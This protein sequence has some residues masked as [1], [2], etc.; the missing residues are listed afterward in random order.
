MGF[1]ARLFGVA[2]TKSSAGAPARAV[3]LRIGGPDHPWV[4]EPPDDLAQVRGR[5]LEVMAEGRP[6]GAASPVDQSA[7]DTMI[8][9]MMKMA[10]LR[11]VYGEEGKDWECGMRMYLRDSIQTQEI[12]F[13]DGRP[14]QVFYTDF[15][16]FGGF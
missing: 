3:D 8:A 11:R 15:S 14:P 13:K 12:L 5:L 6:D 4:C 7:L 2:P 1:F 9:E 10:F 16:R